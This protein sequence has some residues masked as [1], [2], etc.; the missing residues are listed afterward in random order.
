MSMPHLEIYEIILDNYFTFEKQ[1]LFYYQW[2]A[3]YIE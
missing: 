3:D 2:Y 1:D